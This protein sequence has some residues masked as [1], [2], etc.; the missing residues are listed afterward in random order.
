MEHGEKYQREAQS[1]LVEVL[2]SDRELA[3]EIARRAREG[4]NLRELSVRHS[5]R[6]TAK[7]R[8]GT[9]GPVRRSQYGP[10]GRMSATAEI[11][12]IIGPVR[13]Q[14]KWT[15]FRVIA[16]EEPRLED[17][18][19]V[20]KRVRTDLRMELEE[21]REQAYVDSLRAAID[22]TARPHLLKGLFE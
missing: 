18:E 5:E 13:Y 21:Q 9:L 19:K 2:V 20:E 1:T 15:V 10:I 22:H 12:E 4:E 16:R 14:D 6:T 7:E 8:N 3:E 17:F 11:G